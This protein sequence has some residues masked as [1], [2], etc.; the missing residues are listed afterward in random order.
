MVKGLST[1]VAYICFACSGVTQ[2]QIGIF[3]F[4]GNSPVELI[5]ASKSCRESCVSIVPSHDRYKINIECPVCSQVHAFTISQ[6]AFWNTE[7]NVFKCP[8]SGISIFFVGNKKNVTEF[9][10]ENNRLLNQLADENM[11]D[12][13]RRKMN[14]L[15]TVDALLEEKQFCCGC[16]SKNVTPYFAEEGIV[17]K[18][19]KCGNSTL[20]TSPED[21]I[22]EFRKKGKIE[23]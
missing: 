16:G 15:E 20:L 5:C 11:S 9:V 3:K 10:D 17:V 19:D 4:S 18:C 1:T 23:F 2:T 22:D 12:D 21:L 13:I 6:A 8:E 7:I 14:L